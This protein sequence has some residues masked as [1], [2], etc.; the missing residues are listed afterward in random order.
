MRI[1]RS[2]ALAALAAIL[3]LLASCTHSEQPKPTP[4]P[5]SAPL[6]AGGG[7]PL[8]SK[9]DWKMAA[10]L[11]AARQMR[12]GATFFE[13]ERCDVEPQ[14]GQ[15]DW[16]RVDQVVHDAADMGYTMMLKIRAGDCYGGGDGSGVR[17][18]TEATAKTPSSLPTDLN[19]YADFVKT[20]VSRYSAQGVHEYAVENEID[21]QNFWSGSYSD[22]ATL[23]ARAATAIRSADPRA[24]VLDPGLSSTAYGAVLAESMLSD[25][26][27][28]KAL[29]FYQDYYQRR[30]DG[31]ASRFPRATTVQRLQHIL[32]QTMAQRAIDAAKTI[33]GLDRD[34]T[35]DVYQL[36]FYEPVSTLP[37]V[38]SWIHKQMQLPIE[39]WEVGIAW[40]GDF[41][42]DRQAGDTAKL[43]AI[44]L[45]DGIRRVVY[46]PLAP[47]PKAGKTQ[48]FR[49]L[50]DPDGTVTPA[51]K[52]FEKLAGLLSGGVTVR[53]AGLNGLSGIAISGDHGTDFVLWSSA[54]AKVSLHSG[55]SAQSVTGTDEGSTVGADPVFVHRNEPLTEAQ[56]SLI[57]R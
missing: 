17:D 22:F 21:T 40:P 31:G 46:L 6:P 37:D 49:G 1:G 5:T 23:A 2:G 48:I 27:D 14:P 3:T 42:P 44:M 15:Y 29:T 57:A 16:R 12:G 25:G 39:A 4:N 41:D 54:D 52:V 20:L 11:Q 55:V 47:T 53:P 18:N 19:A 45:G 26:E 30:Q 51:G 32:S 10:P 50:T 33:T 9:W 24:K 38:L 36:H 13:V 34:H 28:D 7:N 43:A 8:G 35:F 56:N